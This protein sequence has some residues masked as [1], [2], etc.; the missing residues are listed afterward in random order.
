MIGEHVLAG[1]TPDAGGQEALA[2]A[3][4]VVALTGGRLTIG[5]VHPPD[6]PAAAGESL[7]LLEQA[8]ARLDGEP[9]ELVSHE[10]RG[11][12]RGLST[13]A[14]RVGADLI[15][16]GSPPGGAHHRIA[17]G[18][19][20][21]HLLHSATEAVMVTPAGYAPPERLERITVMYVDRP[22]CEEAVMRAAVAAHM[23]G[24][25]LR[26]VT[27]AM[28][29]DPAGRLRDDLALAIRLALDSAPLTAEDVTAE[30]GEGDDVAGALADLGWVAG[31]LLVCASSED[32]AAHRVFIGEV[33]LK[34]LRAAS[35]PVAVLPRGYS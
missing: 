4:A 5:H 8:A 21:D 20:A 18:T 13:L 35:C 9:A 12:G 11:V 34:A 28:P 29:G 1:Y 25:T 7:T 23:L 31:D 24:A 6:R 10:G 22:Q 32:A 17:V 2:L 15:V 3:R 26:L 27:L 30:L 16:I 33:A 19:A 14:S